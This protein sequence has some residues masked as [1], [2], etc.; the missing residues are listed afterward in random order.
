MAKDDDGIVGLETSQSEELVSDDDVEVVP[1]QNL[2][3]FTHQ[4]QKS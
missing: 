2:I 1:S 4:I 3:F